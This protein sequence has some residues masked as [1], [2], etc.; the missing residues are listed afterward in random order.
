MHSFSVTS[1]GG[2][3]YVKFV[4]IFANAG[5]IASAYLNLIILD[6]VLFSDCEL[7]L[8]PHFSFKFM[9]QIDSNYTVIGRERIFV[10]CVNYLR[11]YLN[12][13]HTWVRPSH[14][15]DHHLFY[16]N[17]LFVME[18][19]IIHCKWCFLITVKWCILIMRKIIFWCIANSIF[20]TREL[21]LDLSPF[22]NPSK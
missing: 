15:L 13:R 6:P 14:D 9:S 1:A 8:D 5:F 16:I 12:M 19:T 3:G 22:W 17:T 20:M 4:E 11:L 2:V 21:F 18:I 10:L 7:Q